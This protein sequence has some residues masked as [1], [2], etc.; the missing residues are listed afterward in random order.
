MNLLEHEEDVMLGNIRV[1]EKNV[2]KNSRCTILKSHC[3]GTSLSFL[4]FPSTV[5]LRE[6]IIM[7][8][9]FKFLVSSTDSRKARKLPSFYRTF[10]EFKDS[11]E[12]F[13]QRFEQ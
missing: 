1:V 9:M 2:E 6:E 8:N 7:R 10:E 13:F 11:L 4:K 12:I 5:N 3:H